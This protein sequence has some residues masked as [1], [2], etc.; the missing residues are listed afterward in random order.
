MDG[1]VVLDAA[2]VAAAEEG[3]VGAVEGRADRDAALGESGARLGDR[4]RQHGAG[5][6]LHM[7]GVADRV[8]VAV[9]VAVQPQFVAVLPPVLRTVHA[10]TVR[11]GG[12][13]RGFRRTDVAVPSTCRST[14]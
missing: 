12:R 9:D 6:F 13:R 5:L 1:V 8:A 14:S 2:V 3:A 7:A 10:L 11:R 4:C